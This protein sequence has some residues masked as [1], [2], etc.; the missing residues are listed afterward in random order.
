MHCPTVKISG[1]DP[2]RLWAYNECER[3]FQSGTVSSIL[4]ERLKHRTYFCLGNLGQI[5]KCSL[6]VQYGF[7][8]NASDRKS[9][10]RVCMCVS[11]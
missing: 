11:I 7:N 8:V 4:S 3:Y 5:G 1:Y 9:E 6:K 10:I 2:S